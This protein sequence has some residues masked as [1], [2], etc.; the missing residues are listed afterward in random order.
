MCY[1]FFG[2]SMNNSIHELLSLIDNAGYKSYIVGGYI[3]D[4]IWG[5][6]NN[7]IDIVTNAPVSTLIKLFE[8]LNPIVLKYNTLKLIHECG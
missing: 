6:S 2:D 7:D 1:N 3:R 8:N 4:L 5:L